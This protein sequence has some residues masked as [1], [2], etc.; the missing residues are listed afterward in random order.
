[1]GADVLTGGLGIDTFRLALA[2][3]P[4]AGIDKITDLKIGTDRIDGPGRSVRP[5]C[6]SWG[7]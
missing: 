2:D 6:G 1:M 4:L 7:R 5:M 3:S